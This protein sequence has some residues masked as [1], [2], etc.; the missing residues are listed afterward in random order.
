MQEQWLPWIIWTHEITIYTAI[1]PNYTVVVHS[2]IWKDCT[3]SIETGKLLI[4]AKAHW[5]KSWQCS[6]LQTHRDR[7]CK[8]QVSSYKEFL[9]SPGQRVVVQ[10]PPKPYLCLVFKMHS[11]GVTIKLKLVIE[12]QEEKQNFLKSSETTHSQH[13]LCLHFLMSPIIQC[14]L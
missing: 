12:T 11:N 2:Q 13:L 7:P 4:W 5:R 9:P 3:L 1:T 8:L 6:L 14:S 10:L